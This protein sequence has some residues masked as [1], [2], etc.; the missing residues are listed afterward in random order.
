MEKCV[1]TDSPPGARELVA[2]ERRETQLPCDLSGRSPGGGQS[3]KGLQLRVLVFVRGPGIF[4]GEPQQRNE[5]DGYAC[6][7]PAERLEPA[8]TAGGVVRAL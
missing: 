1:R 5:R 6:K 8:V 3:P 7:R 2:G 4:C